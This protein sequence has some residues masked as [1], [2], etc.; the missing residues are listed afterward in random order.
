MDIV[1][2]IIKFIFR[3][4]YWLVILPAAVSLLT[5][6]S[7]RNLQRTYN[8]S[9]TIYTG[10]A[11]GYDILSTEGGVWIGVLSIIV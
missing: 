11:S 6:Y 10:I 8:V 1:S 7:T 9:T 2:Q 4:R 5:I 3:I